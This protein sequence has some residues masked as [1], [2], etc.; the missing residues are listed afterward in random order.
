MEENTVVVAQDNAVQSIQ[1]KEVEE[2]PRQGGHPSYIHILSLNT[3]LQ[4]G[5]KA[6]SQ[7]ER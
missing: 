5:L 1:A 3:S 2:V 7:R 4:H 6:E